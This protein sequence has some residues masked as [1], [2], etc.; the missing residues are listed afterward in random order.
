MAHHWNRILL[1]GSLI[2]PLCYTAVK[3]NIPQNCTD[4]QTSSWRNILQMLDLSVQFMLHTRQNPDC[5][6][7]INDSND[8]RNSNFN[9][10]LPTKLI[11]HGY[12]ITGSKPSWVDTLAKELLD[13]MDVNVVIVD[14]IIGSTALYHNVVQNSAELGLKVSILIRDLMSHGSTEDSFHLIGISLGAHVAGFVGRMFKG[15]LG[16]ITGLD[17]AGPKFSKAGVDERLDPG[18]AVFVE[19]IHSDSDY[20]GISR[21]VGHID[22]YLNDGKDQPGCTRPFLTSVYKYLVCDHTRA[23]FVYISSIKNQCPLVA[24]PCQTYELF[25]NGQCTNCNIHPLQRCPRIG[26][27]ERGGLSA[28]V[29]PKEVKVYLMTSSQPPF[30]VK[31]FLLEIFY[32]Q[33][34]SHEQRVK[35]K[36]LS[37]SHSDISNLQLTIPKKQSSESI[38]RKV[39][40]YDARFGNMDD[41]T[42][43]LLSS[44][45]KKRSPIHIEKIRIRELH[46]NGSERPPRCIYNILLYREILF[47]QLANCL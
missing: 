23:I 36:F 7:P 44:W 29:Q 21:P 42:I 9:G 11:M 40:P 27:L 26:L 45:R 30:C 5:A 37:N 32:E 22:F 46:F 6:Q 18:D 1:L 33:L 10:S 20:F 13:A 14:W 25:A 41:I 47:E 3:G 38:I 8:I 16:Q 35:I 17:P 31:H 39:I 2:F 4:F 12:R 15:K 34:G 28:D 43:Q 24:F 19:A